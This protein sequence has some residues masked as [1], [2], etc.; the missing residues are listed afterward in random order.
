VLRESARAGRPVAEWTRLSVLATRLL[1][2]VLFLLLATHTWRRTADP[3]VDWGRE[4]HMAWRV[5]EGDA[6]GSGVITL[7]GPLST[8]FNGWLWEIAGRSMTPILLAN[9]ALGAVAAIC[10]HAVA[11]QVFRTGTAVYLTTVFL[12]VSVFGVLHPFG[13]FNFAAPYSHAATHG[14]V[15][16]YAALACAMA[17]RR[18]KNTGLLSVA[19]LLAG[20][21]LLF[22]PEIGLAA[23]VAVTIAAALARRDGRGTSVYVLLAAAAPAAAVFLLG[24]VIWNPR[25]A[26]S[27]VAGH[28]VKAFA[29]G[30]S[31]DSYYRLVSGLD[32]PFRNTLRGVGIAGA[33]CVGLAGLAVADRTVRRLG[34]SAHRGLAM[35][36]AVTVF[37]FVLSTSAWLA[38]G[39]ALPFL[40]FGILGHLSRATLQPHSPA[41]DAVERRAVD[42]AKV[43]WTCF[44]L[45]LLLKVILNTTLRHYGFVLASPGLLLVLGTMIDDVPPAARRRFGSNVL[46][47][48]VVGALAGALLLGTA[49]RTERLTRM[50]TAELGE[51]GDLLRVY[52]DRL[53]PRPD[54]TRRAIRLASSTAPG[55]LV[56]VIPEGGIVNYLSRRDSPVPTSTVLPP[57]IAAVG[58]DRLAALVEAS[59][60]DLVF[61]SRLPVPDY[62]ARAA[63][64]DDAFGL[65]IVRWIE[66]NYR[67]ET[68]LEAETPRGTRY[69]LEV[70]RPRASVPRHGEDR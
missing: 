30:L 29:V 13:S 44:S 36:A 69:E 45:A 14:A 35:L 66:T 12:F 32:A 17:A 18:R 23:L 67:R 38:I 8:L 5:A 7:F 2:P 34:R 11:R 39:P 49:F 28:W 65:A 59:P 37:L 10:L 58:A 70:L 6:I 20:T 61:L 48:V 68:I 21:S 40:L 16:A 62:G 50:R 24:A 19:S 15:L 51:G 33:L 60:P 4:M 46:P 64:D 3:F 27:L 56:L 57:E 43:L 9:L 47:T 54:P 52:P 26:A 41:D 22:K 42:E 1:L 31:D 63:G 53:D 25:W 55:A